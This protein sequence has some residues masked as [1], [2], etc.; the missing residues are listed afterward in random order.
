MGNIWRPF[1]LATVPTTNPICYTQQRM[2]WHLTDVVWFIEGWSYFMWVFWNKINIVKK[3]SLLKGFLDFFFGVFFWSLSLQ[4]TIVQLTWTINL[5]FRSQPTLIQWVVF[6]CAL[7]EHCGDTWLKFMQCTGGLIP[8]ELGL[9]FC[10]AEG[11][12]WK[13]N[14][15]A[16]FLVSV[17]NSPSSSGLVDVFPKLI[18]LLFISLFS[19]QLHLQNSVNKRLVLASSSFTVQI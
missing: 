14:T 4:L 8:G 10:E 3:N 5:P 11:S 13:E 6:R 19:P 9:L 18:H 17:Q 15:R 12:K 2:I 7:E 16:V 1:P